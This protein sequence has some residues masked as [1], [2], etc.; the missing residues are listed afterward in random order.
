MDESSQD[1]DYVIVGG[2]SAGCVLASRLSENRSLK[3]CLLE[4]GPR[5]RNP[6]IHI[7]LGIALLSLADAYEWRYRSPPQPA[8]AG[9]TLSFYSGR[10][11]G[12]TSSLNGMVYLRGSP[13]DFDDWAALGNDG[14]SFRDVLPYFLKSEGNARFGPSAVHGGDGPLGVSDLRSIAPVTETFLQAAEAMGYARIDDFNAG[15]D[16]EGFGLRQ[17]TQRNGRR[18]SAATAFLR[19]AEKRS[20]LRVIT[21]ALAERLVFEGRRAVGVSVV[22]RGH[23]QTIAA[24]REVIVSCGTYGSPAL[25]LRSGVGPGA[26]LR[27][28]GIEVVADLPGVGRS[29]QDHPFV[30]AQ[31]RTASTDTYGISLRAVPRLIGDLARY[32]VARRGLLSTSALEAGGYVSLAPESDRP[33]IQIVFLSGSSGRSGRVGMGHGYGIS[34]F[35]VRPKSEGVLRLASADARDAPIVDHRV[36][37]DARDLADLVAGLKLARKLCRQKPFER[38]RARELAPGDTIESDDDLAAYVRGAVRSGNHPT[39]TCRMGRDP[40]A[41]VDSALKVRGM[42]SLRVVDASV[43]PRIVSANTNAATIMIAEKAASMILRSG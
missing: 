28:L 38:Y 18:S 7:P 6:L 23:R 13:H 41:V 24:R 1:Y 43:M 21:G 25:L 34:V 33:D 17:V 8:A 16:R 40:R 31:Y 3:V 2:G 11:L 20:N 19:T 42:D 15:E 39:S 30:G 29:L 5:D 4:A 36:L 35:G 14:W 22:V 9:R 26:D 27:M 10:V 37:G 12:G 32:A